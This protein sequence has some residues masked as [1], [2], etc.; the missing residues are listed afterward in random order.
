MRITPET[1]WSGKH[2]AKYTHFL[3]PP[4]HIAETD[5]KIR[6]AKICLMENLSTPAICG[7]FNPGGGYHGIKEETQ[8]G[9]TWEEFL[10]ACVC[11]EFVVK[12]QFGYGGNLV[13]LF[14]KGNGKIESSQF[15][16]M[17]P[18]E[19]REKLKEIYTI[20]PAIIQKR[21]YNHPTL[22]EQFKI[23]VLTTC[24][25]I[26]I[27]EGPG[28]D[29]IIF[30]HMKFPGTGR[31][32]D[33]F[34][35][36]VHGGIKAEMNFETGTIEAPNKSGKNQFGF[37]IIT[38]HPETGVLLKGAK[39]PLWEETCKLALK[40]SRAMNNMRSVGWD[41]AITPEG[42]CLIEGNSAWGFPNTEKNI[43]GIQSE[44]VKVC[45]KL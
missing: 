7:I 23:D 3:N 8:S 5:D 41:I 26:L 1:V 31:E 25:L 19:F 42:P 40:A 37:E 14:R 13:Y 28:T 45:G 27:R 4:E 35:W 29:R 30:A 6:F 36:G 32:I 12:P 24:R 20:C 43:Q 18:I 17:S 15:G 21:V 39:I 22:I 9:L 11:D 34:N 16:S 33:N 38:H 44:L 10:D 2:Y